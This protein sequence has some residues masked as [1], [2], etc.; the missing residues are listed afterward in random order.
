MD[1][2][3][4]VVLTG[5]IIG[6][7]VL[8]ATGTVYMRRQILGKD[9]ISFAILGV[10]LIGGL[11]V[12]H[13]ITFKLPFDIEITLKSMQANYEQV[14]ANLERINGERERLMD[15]VRIMRERVENNPTAPPQLKAQ[16]GSAYQET[17]NRNEAITR[18]TGLLSRDVAKNRNDLRALSDKYKLTR[19]Q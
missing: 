13:Q 18:E 8:I 19:R 7:F 16:I 11:S 9:G 4:V 5:L 15:Q 3:S 6:S 1:I 12:W 17:L 10:L 14:S 2:K